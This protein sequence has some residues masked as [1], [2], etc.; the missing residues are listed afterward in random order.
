MS[1][2]GKQPIVLPKGVSVKVDGAKVSVTG[3]KGSLAL[4][5]GAGVSVALESDKVVVSQIE[6]TKQAKANF[7]TARAN[8]NNL[9]RGVVNGWKKSL[10]MSGVGFTAKV[11]G[12][13]LILSVGFSHDVPLTI[14]AG[15]KCT[16]NKNLIDIEGIDKD[17]VGV[18]AAQV[19][20]T[21]KPEPYL[22][23]GIKYS[24]EVIRR[25]AGKTG[26]K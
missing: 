6:D 10:E 7:G 2:V 17:V 8:I 20:M 26:K 25:K 22:G 12:S 23:K 5:V 14:P 9:V 21:K 18:F 19:R 4:E 1:R 13:S 11:T 24:N 15:T 3:P 16:V